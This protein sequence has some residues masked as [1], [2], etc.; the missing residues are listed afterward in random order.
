MEYHFSPQQSKRKVNSSGFDLWAH[1]SFFGQPI[2]PSRPL[3][4]GNNEFIKLTEIEILQLRQL[5]VVSRK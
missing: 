4:F 3:L 1:A 5:R 2:H